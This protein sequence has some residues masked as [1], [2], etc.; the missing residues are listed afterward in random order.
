MQQIVR[1]QFWPAVLT[2]A[3]LAGSC[4]WVAREAVNVAENRAESSLLKKGI[5]L[6]EK[7]AEGRLV[8][9]A[10]GSFMQAERRT[11]GSVLEVAEEGEVSAAAGAALR[12]A[13]QRVIRANAALRA[14]VQESQAEGKDAV[15]SAAAQRIG[16]KFSI[17]ITV[18]ANRFTFAMEVESRQLIGESIIVGGIVGDVVWQSSPREN[19]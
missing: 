9:N 3:L 6:A 7:Q 10:E 18:N 12:A 8:T 5:V 2:L 17:S 15:L 4:K 19:D 11:Q 13:Q 1:Y 14:F 16:T